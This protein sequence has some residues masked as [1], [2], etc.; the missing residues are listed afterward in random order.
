MAETTDRVVVSRVPV[1]LLELL[2]RL[3]QERTITPLL[4]VL[5]TANRSVGC[6]ACLSANCVGHASKDRVVLR[7][8]Y[9]NLSLA[10]LLLLPVLVQGSFES[11]HL[12][13]DL[14]VEGSL[15]LKF[16]F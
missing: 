1:A 2:R 10:F 6:W 15:L 7:I 8:V 16:G 14:L 5:I 9:R 4:L 11:A 12:L 13:N 3:V